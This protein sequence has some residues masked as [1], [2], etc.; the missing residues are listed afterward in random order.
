MPHLCARFFAWFVR[1]C[2]DWPGHAA[3]RISEPRT[4]QGVN[5]SETY[6][7]MTES[8]PQHDVANRSNLGKDARS[9]APGARG[10]VAEEGVPV[11]QAQAAANRYADSASDVVHILRDAGLPDPLGPSILKSLLFF[12]ERDGDPIT[13]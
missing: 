8:G 6:R 3:A 10:L 7:R 13:P 9:N 11:G 4:Q 1:F 2:L 5:A 12:L